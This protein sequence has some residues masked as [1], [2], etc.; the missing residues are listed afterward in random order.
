MDT[1]VALS[2]PWGRS[3]I[4]VIRLSGPDAQILAE[5]ACASGPRWVPRR[6]S[7]RRIVDRD[8]RTVDEV[9][10]VWMPG[11]NSYTGDDVVEISGHGNPV[12]LHAMLDAFVAQGARPARPGEFTRRALEN[13]RTNV[14]QAESLQALIDARSMDGVRDAQGGMDGAME[15][16]SAQMREALLDI[17]AELEARLDHPDDDL[18][19]ESDQAVTDILRHHAEAAMS[20]ADTWMRSKVRIEGATVALIGPVN[21][22][23]SSLFNHLVGSARAL[24]SDRPGTTRDVVERSVLLDGMDITFLDTAGEGGTDDQL[25]QAGVAL[26]QSLSAQADLRV[27]VVPSDR[28]LCMASRGLI[29]RTRDQRHLLVG[30]FGDR[31]RDPKFDLTDLVVDNVTGLGVNAVNAAVR[32]AVANAPTS[33]GGAVVLSQRQH[34]LFRTIAEHCSAAAVALDGALGPAVAAS[35]LSLIHI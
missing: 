16:E 9:V 31:P 14:L 7:V 6:A 8:G 4:G 22:G 33:P 25:E 24:V 17:A 2:T 35:E 15:A 32:S 12:I 10:A 27:V 28:P 13:G 11:P 20:T 3:A 23:K 18:S 5:R 30:T 26:G 21:A 34:D 29:D 19:L 1:I